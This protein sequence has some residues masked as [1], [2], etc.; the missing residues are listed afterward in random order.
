MRPKWLVLFNNGTMR[1]G[2]GGGGAG[3]AGVLE[4]PEVRAAAH[5]LLIAMVPRTISAGYGG[6]FGYVRQL[7]KSMSKCEL[8]PCQ[9]R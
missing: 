3:G 4:A 8:A 9:K 2:G 1:A 5:Q 6:G 7:I